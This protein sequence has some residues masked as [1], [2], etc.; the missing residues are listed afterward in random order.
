MKDNYVPV[1]VERENKKELWRDAELLISSNTS[2]N[3]YV[4]T[5]KKN[6]KEARMKKRTKSRRR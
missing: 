2:K 5:H 6:K 1:L 4:R 3:S